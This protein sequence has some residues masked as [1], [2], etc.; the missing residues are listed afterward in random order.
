[1][2]I[3]ALVS[4]ARRFPDVWLFDELARELRPRADYNELKLRLYA[5]AW[6][7]L[8]AQGDNAHLAALFSGGMVT[9]L[10]RLGQEIR[11][12]YR[13]GHFGYAA[14]PSPTY[15]ICR[16]VEEVM[17]ATSVLRLCAV[18]GGRV[19]VPPECAGTTESLS[20]EAQC[21]ADRMLPD[22]AA[23]AAAA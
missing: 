20:P 16:S 15:L 12:S 18:S 13:H 17:E 2:S 23:V 5:H 1:L 6:F 3:C 4:W 10:H 9:I 21:G 19:L 22:D 7:H 11:H 14:Q 8:T